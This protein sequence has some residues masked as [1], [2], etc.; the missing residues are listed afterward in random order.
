MSRAFVTGLCA[1]VC[2]ACAEPP[3]TAIGTVR[4]ALH[5]SVPSEITGVLYAVTCGGVEQEPIYVALEAEGLPR[6]VDATLAGRPF[7]DRFAIVPAGVCVVTVFPMRSPS[8]VS[9]RCQPAEATVNVTA[10]LTTEAT[11]VIRCA[12]T[13]GAV[14]VVTVIDEAPIIDAVAFN[15]SNAVGTCTSVLIVPTAHDPDGD[16]VLVQFSVTA[17]PGGSATVSAQ[18]G[19]AV[20]TPLA[21]GTYVVTVTATANGA[22]TTA[23][24]TLIA[25]GPACATP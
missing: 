18:G 23:Q 19:S 1:L 4:L 11:L 21:P 2:L 22:A 10:E 6:E 9:S 5:G 14:D 16:V 12:A 24:A 8:E 15:P 25:A 20:V 13:A 17:P 3:E 7:A